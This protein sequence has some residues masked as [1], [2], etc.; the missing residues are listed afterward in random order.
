MSL[1]NFHIA[2]NEG[3]QLQFCAKYIFPGQEPIQIACRRG[4]VREV[5]R[6][7]VA[8]QVLKAKPEREP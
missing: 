8:N 3:T 6:S 2:S 5:L 7:W 1:K 4:V